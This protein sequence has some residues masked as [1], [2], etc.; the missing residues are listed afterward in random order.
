MK[1]I[2]TVL[3]ANRGE[4]A[5]RIFATCRAQGI[6]SAAVFTEAD[7]GTPFVL[8]ADIGVCIGEG[9]A[10]TSYL[11][12]EKLLEAAKRVGADAIHPGY[13]FL[14]ENAPFA[15]AVQ[16]AG[17]IWIGPSPESINSMGDKVTARG[18]AA[19]HNVP[20]VPGYDGSQD[21][22]E[23][24]EAAAEIGYPVLIKATAGGG[25]RG[26]RRVNEA[27]EFNEAVESA[28]REA[29]SAFGNGNVFLE[30]FIEHPRHIEVQVI[31]DAHGTT[32]H[33]GERE[34]SVQRRHQ[35]IIEEA[36]SP[37]VDETLRTSLGEAAI[38]MAKAVAYTGA[39]TV[40]FIMNAEGVFYFLEM[41]T[42][43]QVEHPVTEQVTGL[44][45]VAL[46]FAIA[47]GKPLE[48]TQ[49]DVGMCGH[50]IEARI[51]AEEP[52]RDYAPGTGPLLRC[53]WPSG[54]GVRV[55]AGFETGNVIS[56]Y[57]DSMLAKV[58]V[59][60][61]SREQATQRM[62]SA[63]NQTWV[64]GPATNIPLLKDI[65]ATDRWSRG[66][67]ETGFLALEGLPQPPPL[68]FERGLIA[69]TC[70]RWWMKRSSA[71]WGPH[72]PAGWRVEGPAWQKDTWQSFGSAAQVRWKAQD[73]GLDIEIQIEEQEPVIHQARHLCVD[74]STLYLEL[75]GIQHRWQTLVDPTERR[76]SL[77]IEDGD[78]VFVQ[79]GDGE[80]LVCLSPR[81]PAPHS[82]SDEPGTL[83]AATPGTV[84]RVLVTEGEQVEA[85]QDLIVVEA[86]KM[87]QRL[88]APTAGLISAVL[89]D[90]GE[91]VNQG[92]TLLRMDCEDS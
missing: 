8:E 34:C 19:Q 39:G 24:A 74:Q 32:L 18:I 22:A 50:S 70:I 84:V 68:H 85:G 29:L 15:Q 59:S 71:P 35:K 25:G 1:R 90:E 72:I 37:A 53:Q 38:R 60:G 79:L 6:R 14:S 56:P 36:P 49:S 58:I 86:M 45:L 87:E 82:A 81:L 47:E 23:L 76:P 42:R 65:F 75:N 52:A 43:L 11:N 40:E 9:P 10:S 28:T 4:I 55:D 26:M 7:R 21:T 5:R 41:N 61:A 78:R 33:L 12:T 13:G 2:S 57:Y 17:L 77:D 73:G 30:K 62:R 20:T 80:A 69:A 92:D 48:L 46:Q 83:T 27:S 44:D 64:V 16:D 67:L 54:E 91:T 3:V 88:S 89:V 63:L 31:A 51:Y 66:E